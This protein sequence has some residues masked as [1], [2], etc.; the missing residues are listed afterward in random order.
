MKPPRM[1]ILVLTTRCNLSCRYCYMTASTSGSDMSADVL[2]KAL[3]M[4]LPGQPCHV[5]LTGGEPT[6]VPELIEK[7]AWLLRT[8]HTESSLAIQ[9]NAT[10]L[11]PDL[12]DLF[13]KCRIQVGVSLDGPPDI[14]QILRGKADR[15]YRG[16]QLL[17]NLEVPFRVT[18]VVSQINVVHLPKLALLLSGFRQARGL[19][20]DLLVGKGRAASINGPSPAHPEA[21]SQAVAAMF[22]ALV[23]I[24]K[25]RERPL[26]LR[27]MEMLLRKGGAGR[28]ASFC[29]ACRGECVAVNPDGR[30]FPC[31]QTLG[32]EKFAAGDVWNPDPAKLHVLSGRLL[33]NADCRDCE[34]GG[35]CPGECPS[36]LHYN[37]PDG[38]SLV[39]TL[40]KTLWNCLRDREQ[41]RLCSG[42]TCCPSDNDLSQPC[43]TILQ[44]QYENS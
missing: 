32:D 7:T 35:A 30:I 22:N 41:S 14:Q 40:Y 4:I 39:C 28:V 8:R 27:E 33:T 43:P 10:L 19:G 25:Q 17:E 20:L 15:T 3:N 44:E 21:L 29:H 37:T 1:L 2:E 42:K 34:L 16:L 23:F 36:R 38:A 31:G 6:L 11:T 5:Q 13:K 18:T 9:T 26:Q 12:L 24:N